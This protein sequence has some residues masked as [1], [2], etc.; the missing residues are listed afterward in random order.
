MECHILYVKSRKSFEVRRQ[1]F[2]ITFLCAKIKHTAKSCFAVC[3]KKVAQKKSTQQTTTLPCALVLS[4]VFLSTL[5]K[6]HV[7]RVTVNL[8]TANRGAH[9]KHQVCSVCSNQLE[10]YVK[11]LYCIIHLLPFL[12]QKHPIP[13]NQTLACRA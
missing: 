5:G 8:H 6:T 13:F 3:H 12:G 9:G 1:N 2:F 11:V 10:L 7:C 4:C